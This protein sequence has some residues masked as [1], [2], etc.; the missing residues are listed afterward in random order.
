MATIKDAQVKSSLRFRLKLKNIIIRNYTHFTWPLRISGYILTI[1]FCVIAPLFIPLF[2]W[3]FYQSELNRRKD[4]VMTK[5]NNWA[6]YNID[7]A[8]SMGI[9]PNFRKA[10][11]A[12]GITGL[13]LDTTSYNADPTFEDYLKKG[14]KFPVKEENLSR[15]DLLRLTNRIKRL[16]KGDFLGCLGAIVFGILFI[17]KLIK[18]Y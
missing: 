17:S 6:I 15:E 9:E 14:G 8:R 2:L 3:V 1:S 13:Y 16:E 10:F 7:E 18:L 4:V 5:L 12:K 11:G